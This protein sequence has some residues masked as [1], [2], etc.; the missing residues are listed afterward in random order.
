MAVKSSRCKGYSLSQAWYLQVLTA[1]SKAWIAMQERCCMHGAWLQTIAPNVTL[2]KS[3]DFPPCHFWSGVSVLEHVP[4]LLMLDRSSRDTRHVLSLPWQKHTHALWSC[5]R[6]CD[7]LLSSETSCGLNSECIV[8]M[9]CLK[10]CRAQS[11]S[12]QGNTEAR[13][14]FQRLQ[15]RLETQQIFIPVHVGGLMA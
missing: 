9:I 10:A 8:A 11:E 7:N 6:L 5:E 4:N 2:R 12:I 15:R 1:A 13:I 14:F 3:L